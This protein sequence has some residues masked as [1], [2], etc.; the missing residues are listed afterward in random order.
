MS[1]LSEYH[2]RNEPPDKTKT[3][4]AG[5]LIA[6]ILAGGVGY[7]VHTGMFSSH[8]AQPAKTYPRGL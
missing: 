6:V 4:V 8:T 2:H 1:N 7:A 3:V 5:I